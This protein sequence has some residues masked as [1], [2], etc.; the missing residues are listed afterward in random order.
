MAKETIKSIA[1]ISASSD[2][3]ELLD[4]LNNSKES[5][6]Y[7]HSIMLSTISHYLVKK[8]EWGT[9]EQQEKIVFASFFHDITIPDDRL[10]IINTE[11]QLEASEL[12]DEEKAKVKMNP[13]DFFNGS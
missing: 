8:M 10:N 3:T 5:Y 12:S 9:K 2:I 11:E 13:E 1:E 4:I 6:L 7:R